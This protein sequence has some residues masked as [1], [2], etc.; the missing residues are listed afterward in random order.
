MQNGVF[1]CLQKRQFF[2]LIQQH[3]HILNIDLFILFLQNQQKH[4]PPFLSRQNQDYQNFLI[5][6]QIVKTVQ[7]QILNKRV[8]EGRAEPSVVQRILL[9]CQ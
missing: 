4:L 6:Y 2:R 9:R 3:K 7:Q 8:F 5:L 1:Q